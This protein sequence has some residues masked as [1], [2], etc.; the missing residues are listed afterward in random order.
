MTKNRWAH[1][2][3]KLSVN[4]LLWPSLQGLSTLLG[5]DSSYFSSLLIDNPDPAFAYQMDGRGFLCLRKGHQWLGIPKINGSPYPKTLWN[6]H[7]GS[8]GE[9]IRLIFE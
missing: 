6:I 8:V 2:S 9:I 5:V 4:P 1:T 7:G 3:Q